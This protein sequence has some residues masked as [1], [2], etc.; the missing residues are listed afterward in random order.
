[1]TA[2]QLSLVVRVL[3]PGLQVESYTRST[4]SYSL[5]INAVRSTTP[6]LCTGCGGVMYAS[7]NA[8]SGLTKHAPELSC[9]LLLLSAIIGLWMRFNHENLCCNYDYTLCLYCLIKHL[10]AQTRCCKVSTVSCMLVIAWVS[11]YILPL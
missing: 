7:I 6:R 1:M 11:G 2:M 9:A 10:Y 5:I 4:P 8:A 3:L